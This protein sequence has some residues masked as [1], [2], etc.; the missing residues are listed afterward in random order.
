MHICADENEL[1][2]W[3]RSGQDLSLEWSTV[4]GYFWRRW[5]HCAVCRIHCQEYTTVPYAEWCV[6]IFLLCS[7]VYLV[8][9]LILF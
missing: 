7:A 1:I 8:F 3:S 6:D 5:R 4:D 2:E 9:L